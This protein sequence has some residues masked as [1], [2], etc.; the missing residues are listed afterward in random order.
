[1]LIISRDHAGQVLDQ[2]GAYQRAVDQGDSLDDAGEEI[3]TRLDA[4]VQYFGPS[5]EVYET[6]I[7]PAIEWAIYTVAPKWID[8]KE[9]QTLAPKYR[10]IQMKIGAFYEKYSYLDPQR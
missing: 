3:V 1:M 4:V 7:K 5:T 2:I 10:E 8:P 6:L 9:D